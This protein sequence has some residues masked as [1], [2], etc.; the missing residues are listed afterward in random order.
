[1]TPYDAK[2]MRNAALAGADPVVFFE[3]QRVYDY[4]EM[5]EEAG[6]PEG[7]YESNWASHQ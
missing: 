2:G 1:M 7:Y 4:G 3:S 6:V 5:F